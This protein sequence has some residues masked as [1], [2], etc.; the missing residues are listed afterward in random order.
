MPVRQPAPQITERLRALFMRIVNGLAKGQAGCRLVHGLDP[1]IV[2]ELDTGYMG[3]PAH[4]TNE[5]CCHFS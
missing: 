3:V 4:P 5:T 2:V 1:W